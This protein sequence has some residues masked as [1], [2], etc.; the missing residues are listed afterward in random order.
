MG[1]TLQ[2]LVFD[3]MYFIVFHLEYNIVMTEITVGTYFCKASDITSKFEMTRN[4]IDTN[5][6]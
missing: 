4:C 5:S 1:Q 3:A 2:C 6:V